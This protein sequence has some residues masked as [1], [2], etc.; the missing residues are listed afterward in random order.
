MINFSDLTMLSIIKDDRKL[1]R[2]IELLYEDRFPAF[3]YQRIRGTVRSYL[4]TADVDLID[5]KIAELVSFVPE[6]S[7][8]VGDK[9]NCLD[10]LNKVKEMVFPFTPD[11][12]RLKPEFT[13]FSLGPIEVKIVPDV[14]LMWEGPDGTKHVGAV[15]KKIKKGRL[16]LN[17]ATMTASLLEYYLKQVYPDFVVEPGMCLCYD[18]F[19]HR[20]IQPL[21]YEANIERAKAVAYMIARGSAA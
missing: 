3:L 5:A 12:K 20:M 18:V 13:S 14:V 1:A 15:Y 17:L 10:A 8:Q 11:V 16:S 4:R 9:Q 21:N 6:K 19:R 7:W 2:K